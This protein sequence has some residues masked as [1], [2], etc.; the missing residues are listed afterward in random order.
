MYNKFVLAAILILTIGAIFL[1]YK[2]P[3]KMLLL[4]RS[5]FRIKEQRQ[6]QTI[7][8]AI[9]LGIDYT[10]TH[11]KVE[12]QVKYQLQVMPE[13]GRNFVIE[14]NEI[15]PKNMLK[16]LGPGSKIS[17]RY[18]PKNLKDIYLAGTSIL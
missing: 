8:P 6:T 9:V 15:V 1:H 11:E 5:V 7:S 3:A 18:N 2:I 12:I 14:I 10:D 13:K 4:I 17:V 16:K